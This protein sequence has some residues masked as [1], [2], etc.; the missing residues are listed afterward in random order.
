MSTPTRESK[1]ASP[2]EKPSKWGLIRKKMDLNKLQKLKKESLKRQSK[3][4]EPSKDNLDFTKSV[5]DSSNNVKSK[6][7]KVKSLN[8]EDSSSNSS[9]ARAFQMDYH[10][11]CSSPR[12]DS[13]SYKTPKRI[14][15]KEN[16][17]MRSKT[18]PTK[19]SYTTKTEKDYVTI[20]FKINS[21]SSSGDSDSIRESIA[22]STQ[23]VSN[24]LDQDKNTDYYSRP[25]CDIKRALKDKRRQSV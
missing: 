18:L 8:I 9:P 22:S 20:N 19:P 24:P 21:S 10:E 12:N 1:I 6:R 17:I 7:K 4:V 11:M 16:S 13:N 3:V 14:L 5:F 25:N 2:N 23:Q 15:N